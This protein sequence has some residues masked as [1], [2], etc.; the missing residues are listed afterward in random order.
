MAAEATTSSAPP[1]AA[2]PKASEKHA[3]FELSLKPTEHTAAP[4][5]EKY[6]QTEKLGEGSF[7]V[8]HRVVHKASGREFADKVVEKKAHAT[9][10]WATL[11]QEVTIWEAFAH[12]GVLKLV[13]VI[14]TE[15]ALHLIT[16]MMCGGELFDQLEHVQ[17]FT[18][19][20][21]QLVAVQIASGLAH[22]H[23]KHQVA[24]CDIK[25]A[26]I[27]CCDSRITMPGCVKLADFGSAQRFSEA[28]VPEFTQECGTLEYY[29]PELCRSALE[30]T[31]ATAAAAAA[32]A[33]GDEAA[34]IASASAQTQRYSEAVDCWALGCV[35]YELFYGEPPY[36]SS[37]DREQ[38]TRILK[39]ELCFPEVF[40]KVSSHA[41]QLITALLEPDPRSR[42]CM[43][44]VL[45]H[46]WFA[47]MDDP[48]VQ[49]LLVQPDPSSFVRNE[50]EARERS[51]DPSP[52]P[53]RS[54]THDFD[55]HSFLY[56][57]RRARSTKR[58]SSNSMRSRRV[59]GRGVRSHA[60]SADL[61]YL[62]GDLTDLKHAGAYNAY[63]RSPPPWITDGADAAEG[64]GY[65]RWS[66]DDSRDWVVSDERSVLAVAGDAAGDASASGAIQ[67]AP[68]RR[69]SALF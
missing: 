9:D 33:A 61:T 14:D 25:P 50:H 40:D 69:L 55:S 22:L 39:H 57:E 53:T 47:L 2:E 12:P 49:Q 48:V 41:K 44:E 31:N 35:I 11:L 5:V 54:Y 67:G 52:K 43:N 51:G 68:A 16:E 60:L 24:H 18:E 65:K 15:T 58:R 10:K 23:L 45:R 34:A 38:V 17:A 3:A 28:G 32:A 8:V 46:R 66:S 30:R 56:G 26:N 42:C 37:D 7:G 63:G 19:K 20:G 29:S 62:S 64:G 59:G 13:E 21:V 27:L 1:A 36:W 4:L 6:V